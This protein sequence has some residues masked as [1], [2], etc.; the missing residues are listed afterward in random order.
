M[1]EDEGGARQDP[2]EVGPVDAEQDAW[3]VPDSGAQD[4]FDIEQA[5]ET[6]QEDGTL[7]FSSALPGVYNVRVTATDGTLETS[8]E[9]S[10]TVASGVCK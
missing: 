2:P 8:V 3:S 1:L 4:V 6:A 9:T 5:L 7:V 10:I